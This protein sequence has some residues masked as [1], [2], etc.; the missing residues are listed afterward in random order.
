MST[1]SRFDYGQQELE[2]FENDVYA[3]E[4]EGWSDDIWDDAFGESQIEIPGGVAPKFLNNQDYT[5][6]SPLIVDGVDAFKLFLS[7]GRR[8]KMNY[9]KGWDK[10]KDAFKTLNKDWS[11]LKK[12]ELFHN[13]CSK[14][15]LDLDIPK[16]GI[17]DLVART[18]MHARE[19]HRVVNAYFRAWTGHNIEFMSRTKSSHLTWTYGALMLESL[20]LSWLM[21]ASTEYELEELRKLIHFSY[22]KPE[23]KRLGVSYQSKI[24]GKVSVSG[25][26]VYLEKINMIWDRNMLLMFKDTSTARFHTLFAIQHRPFDHYYRDHLKTIEKLYKAGDKV[27]L[28]D[29]DSAYDVFGVVEPL[30][31]LMLAEM[32]GRWRPLIPPFPHFRNHITQK[33]RELERLNP[34]AGEFFS[35]ISA[36]TDKRT[37]LTVYGSFRH[38]GHPFIRYLDGL[39]ALYKN[40]Q[41][42][43]MPVDKA[44]ANLLASDLTFKIL[45]KEFRMK[46]RWFIDPTKLPDDH[47]LKEHVI[48]N[49]WPSADVLLNYPDSWNTLPLIP[50]W[51]IP[52]VV[53]PAII[54]SDKTHSIQKSELINHLVTRPHERI[55][56][57]KVL[58]T[59]LRM[60][61][62]D[63]PRFLEKVN[64]EGLDEDD[65]VIG[66]KA[67]EREIKRKGRFFALMSWAL[68]EYFVFTEYLIKKN[69][70]PLFKGLTMADDQ[71]TLIRKMLE[72][73]SGQGG[74]SYEHVTI[75][76]HIDYEKW[77]N[78]Q[79]YDATEPVFTVIG[80]FFGLPNLFSRTHEFF[81]KSLVYYRDRPDLMRVVNGQVENIDPVN[82][83]V[84]W[85]GQRGG[86]EGLR[87]KGWSV[88]NLLVIE[89]EGKIRNTSIKILAQGDNQV[90]CC[91]YTVHAYTDPADLLE[92]LIRIMKNNEVI[93]NRIRDATASIGLRINEDETL[94]AADM[95]IYGKSIM[96]RGN[97]T[98]LEEKRLSRITCTTND[99]LPSLSNILSTVSTNCLTVSHYSKSPKNA[100]LHYN[101]LGNLV[102]NILDLHNPALR[103]APKTVTDSIKGWDSIEKRILA[104]YLDPSLGGISGMSLTRF[105]VRMFPDPVTEA[106]TFWKMVYQGTQDRNLKNLASAVGNPRLSS[107]NLKSLTRLIEDPSSL[108]IPRGISAQNLIKEEIKRAMLRR[109]DQI[110]NEIVK[111]AVMYT[112][113]NESYFLAYLASITPLF[114][115]FLSEFKSATYFG[116]TAGILGLFENSKTIRN[117]FKNKFRDLVDAAIVRCELNSIQSLIKK[118]QEKHKLM[119]SCSASQADRLR[120]LSWGRDVVGTTIPHPAEMIGDISTSPSDCGGCKK[121]TPF[122]THLIVLVPLGMSSPED[123]RGPYTPYLGSSTS[124]NTSLVQ[125]W[126]KDTDIS[127]IRRASEMRRAYNWLT[128]PDSNVGKT[129]ANNLIKMTGEHSGGIIT[130]FK[131]TG[132]PLHR[133]SCSRVSPGGYSAS[134]SVYGSRMIIS[135]DNF[136]HLGEDNF[137]FM[138]QPTMLY[139]QQTVGEL[140]QELSI[141]RTY[142]FHIYC[143]DCV[144][145]IQEPLL[146]SPGTFEFSDVSQI[147]N[148]WKPTNGPWFKESNNLVIPVG[149]WESVS[150]TDRSRHIG[151]AQGLMFGLL[152]HSYQ[153]TFVL[154]GLFPIALRNKV[155]GSSYL[156]GLKDGLYRAAVVDASH[157]RIFY[158]FDSIE[159]VIRSCYTIIVQELVRYPD[160]LT[161]AH[162]EAITYMLRLTHH[163][164]PPSYPL[165]NHDLGA[166]AKSA[167]LNYTYLNWK[168]N[169]LSNLP[170]L[171]IFADFVSVQL[172]GMMIISYELINYLKRD[173][174]T[175]FRDKAREL[176]Q[177]MASLRSNEPGSGIQNIIGLHSSIKM[178]QSEIR[179][180]VKVVKIQD[181]LPKFKIPEPVF[182]NKVS[183][184]VHI[185][186]VEYILDSVPPPT[187]IVPRIQNPLISGIRIPQISTGSFIKLEAL[188]DCL[189]LSPEDILCG[190]DGSGGISSSLL[191]R[192]PASRLI[193]N[194]L[195]ELDGV[196]LGG[197]LPSPPSALDYMPSRVKLRC[198]NLKN[199][200]ELPSDLS[201]DETWVGFNKLRVKYGLFITL[202][203]LDMEIRSDQ[204]TTQI[205]SCLRRNLKPLL[206][207]GGTL[208]L[209]TY[210]HRLFSI[211]SPLIE[212][213]RMFNL[214]SVTQNDFSSSH[215]SE[216][217]IVF[218]K[219][220]S[221]EIIGL[222]PHWESLRRLTLNGFCF[223]NYEDEFIRAQSMMRQDLTAGIPPQYLPDPQLELV[224]IWSSIG[225]DRVVMMKMQQLMQTSK[226][227][228]SRFA[229]MTAYILS[230]QVINT[231]RWERGSS[232]TIP[233]DGELS[234]LFSYYAGVLLYFALVNDRIDVG[235]FAQKLIDR[236]FFIFFYQ[237]SPKGSILKKNPN[238]RL[239][240]WSFVETPGYVRYKR[241]FL[242]SSLALIG[243]TIRYFLSISKDPGQQHMEIWMDKTSS[244]NKSCSMIHAV[245]K[246]GIL[247]PF[248]SN[249]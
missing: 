243:A 130:G 208:I 136:H 21:N 48:N 237:T 235:I 232:L 91:E 113:A 1:G 191:R 173:H 222:Y 31:S 75:A 188:L 171:W 202:I 176:S 24:F 82:K 223:K 132:S 240:S 154:K 189:R 86:L 96:Y 138:Y 126:E 242:Q 233:S 77:N 11:N 218:Q 52:E 122:N 148:K 98:C 100:M 39:A 114:P 19:T 249:Y 80:K 32:A 65:L 141:S 206:A 145:K 190:G 63:W 12:T 87:Q 219:L 101:W 225:G 5:L 14:M 193:F 88:L 199:A 16:D 71:T 213:G 109:P 73:S 198:V 197:S 125:S 149:D 248:S 45:K 179:H 169:S 26:F 196:Q 59:L 15:W 6:N 246:T 95:L 105:H 34:K 245:N 28:H 42:I 135:T 163:R 165:N 224:Q 89:R 35:V 156:M 46:Y 106:L 212:L 112:K 146:D 134:N 217:Y 231:T 93:I 110:N 200:W 205:E 150:H 239:T 201:K 119:W 244:L 57:R 131:R 22:L 43:E 155:Q 159:L 99:Q 209:K 236:P 143:S 127:F 172:S 67:K 175:R 214:V 120:K 238:S 64:R 18:D 128:L 49:T 51:D 160:F 81:A 78:F 117:L 2:I 4:Y 177:L 121:D 215:T 25:G 151:I 62:T 170:C 227:S 157:R 94:Q 66:L 144:R 166:M 133:F 47:P 115:R 85:N 37:L 195:L 97:F 194:S 30:S 158:R 142:H 108:N 76:N 74:T 83:R 180:S 40:V 70:I 61:A 204:M 123:V 17:I 153:D 118:S 50:C 230:V 182:S 69:V 44:Y 211:H 38:W 103:C 9:C 36:I 210:I 178:C 152:H 207:D 7:T 185:Y 221:H 53:D 174:I 27:L 162:G 92:E 129:I 241:V 84:C 58:N 216:V 116:L 186:P 8:D 41:S 137:D 90:I 184:E 164:I 203:V 168:Q 79:R 226:A 181:L 72:N 183:A 161:F 68:R 139:A 60:P 228:L 33:M 13:E 140:H 102:L 54:Y 220:R 20:K 55:P 124:E 192:F 187:I 56:T 107:Y 147:L 29:A 23:Q 3:M 10:I 247:H 229:I 167:L 234:R 104:L 111:D